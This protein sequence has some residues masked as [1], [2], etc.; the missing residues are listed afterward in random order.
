MWNNLCEV[1]AS[2]KFEYTCTHVKKG[3]GL[4][5][6]GGPV[7]DD[8]FPELFPAGNSTCVSFRL[9]NTIEIIDIE[10]VLLSFHK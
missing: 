10:C 6:A 9:G 1:N 8:E 4:I 2:Y 5:S 7:L 3:V